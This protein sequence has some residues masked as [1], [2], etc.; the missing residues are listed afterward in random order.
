MMKKINNYILTLLIIILNNNDLL[1][2]SS[3]ESVVVDMS[4]DNNYSF[5]CDGDITS[6]NSYYYIFGG[7]SSF[8]SGQLNGSFIIHN[9]TGLLLTNQYT[10]TINENLIIAN[11][12]NLQID[13]FSSFIINNDI[14]LG[15]NNGYI[16]QLFLDIKG[17]MIVN[18]NIQLNPNSELSSSF[19]KQPNIKINGGVINKGGDLLIEESIKVHSYQQILGNIIFDVSKNNKPHLDSNGLV[20]IKN[21][22]ILIRANS[23]IATINKSASYS[24]ITSHSRDIYI[25]ENLIVFYLFNENTGVTTEIKEIPDHLKVSYI[26][27]EN[28]DKSLSFIIKLERINNNGGN[29]GNNTSNNIEI[30]SIYNTSNTRDI[31]NL[32]NIWTSGNYET[33]KH[34]ESV[35]T[36]IDLL[37]DNSLDYNARQHQLL[38]QYD[39]LKPI[40]NNTLMQNTKSINN[41][42]SDEFLNNLNNN[43]DYQGLFVSNI[44]TNS[45]L[46]DLNINEGYYGSSSLYQIGISQQHNNFTYHLGL[47]TGSGLIANSNDYYN[48]DIDFYGLMAGLKYSAPMNINLLYAIFY[49][50][51]NYNGERIFIDGYFSNNISTKHSNLQNSIEINFNNNIYFLNLIPYSNLSYNTINAPSYQENGDDSILVV[52]GFKSHIITPKLGLKIGNNIGYNFAR[53]NFFFIYDFNIQKEFYRDIETDFTFYQNNTKL[54]VENEAYNKIFT[55]HYLSLNTHLY[56][57]LLN[58]AYSTKFNNQYKENK[59]ILKL[60]KTFS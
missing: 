31:A 18:G 47:N 38:R 2:N 4:I 6:N 27:L 34:M 7:I 41:I 40:A 44:I 55:S 23:A 46:D 22:K 60:H 57:F 52:N 9:P 59:V 17:D 13:D 25:N 10:L 53:V 43:I 20:E 30:N 19:F 24:F 51:I 50:Q 16:P 45:N 11:D 58:I 42:I 36:A 26:K 48:L 3:C 54:K 37:T 8:Q 39:S 29:N 1:A 12:L 5:I 35:I 32:F 56:S 49:N 15:S 33:P 14:I 21:G 28:V